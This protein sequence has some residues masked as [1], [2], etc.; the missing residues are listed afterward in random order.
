MPLLRIMCNA[1]AAQAGLP[2]SPTCLLP[3]AAVP[4]ASTT[5]HALSRCCCATT[6]V[7]HPPS[8]DL[9]PPSITAGNDPSV[10]F[11]QSAPADSETASRQP[12]GGSSGPSEPID[13][14]AAHRVGG[15]D[16]GSAA[17]VI[18]DM[19]AGRQGRQ[20]VQDVRRAFGPGDA[21]GQCDVLG[22]WYTLV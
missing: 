10:A 9:H 20:T 2:C 13:A 3:A 16:M 15:P 17:D 21:G 18:A 12:V 22:C 14:D 5:Y 19:A 11:G 7:H 6:H 8:N 1:S 4:V